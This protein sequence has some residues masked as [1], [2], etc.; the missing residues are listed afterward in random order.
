M[1]IHI[2]RLFLL[3]KHLA[4]NLRVFLLNPQKKLADEA[5]VHQTRIF[6]HAYEKTQTQENLVVMGLQ[7]YIVG[8][9]YLE[10]KRRGLFGEDERHWADRIIF[11]EDNSDSTAHEQKRQEQFDK[12][13]PLMR[14]IKGRRSIRVFKEEE[15]EELVIR[16]AIEA[17]TWSPS[18]CN[19]QPWR[20]FV[21]RAREELEF[22]GSIKER[23]LGKVPAA[24]LMVISKHAYDEVDIHYTPYFDAG[25][26][27]QNM[28]LALW[29]IGYGSAVINLGKKEISDSNRRKVYETYNISEEDWILGALLPFGVPKRI[30]KPPGRKANLEDMIDWKAHEDDFQ[31]RGNRAEIS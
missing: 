1:R 23:W 26:A 3:I 2:K 12:D 20:V 10:V 29:D 25:I 4:N 14:V 31:I 9:Y 11:G 21:L 15:V 16:R 13:S 19:R 17:M 7:L 27:L 5:L 24:F 28:S 22:F 6:V 18:A 8:V 30:P